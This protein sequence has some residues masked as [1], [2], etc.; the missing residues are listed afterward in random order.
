LKNRKL[1]VGR[2]RRRAE[3]A[4]LSER[5]YQ[6]IKERIMTLTFL[7]G[8]YLNGGAISAELRLGRTPVHQALQRLR[9]EGLVD[10]LP[11]KGVIIQADSINLVLQTLDARI[12]I[13]SELARRA[14]ELAD[15][16]DIL[17]LE[18]ILRDLT[19][20]A[21]S[22]DAY[23][24]VDRSFH[25]KIA[26]IGRNEVLQQIQKTLHERCTRSWYLFL[27]QSLEENVSAEQHNAVLRAIR[28]HDAVRAGEAM[29]AHLGSLKGKFIT[30]HEKAPAHGAFR[31]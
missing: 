14:A 24:A 4:S 18:A 25:Q 30:V 22:V 31:A 27:W 26:A 5:A 9:A 15:D 28:N 16:S 6:E 12:V 17:T 8:Q 2:A 7:P 19:E 29:S 10:I 21:R 13:E 3:G 1:I 11:R 23:L 20:K